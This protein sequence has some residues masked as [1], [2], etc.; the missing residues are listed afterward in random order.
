MA[1]N[2][3]TYIA[4]STAFAL[5]VVE[6]LFSGTFYIIQ[7]FIGPIIGIIVLGLGIGYAW[8]MFRPKV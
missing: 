8:R 7:Q 1:E 2:I 4:T 5:T 3:T 6:S